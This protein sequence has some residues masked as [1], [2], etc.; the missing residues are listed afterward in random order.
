MYMLSHHGV[1]SVVENLLKKKLGSNPRLSHSLSPSIV[2]DDN[3]EREN[4]NTEKR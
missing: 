4:V 3:V 1:P 2:P